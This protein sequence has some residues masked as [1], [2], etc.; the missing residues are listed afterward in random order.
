M[1]PDPGMS[2]RQA[3]EDFFSARARGA[4][5]EISARLAGSP[6]GLL[7]YDEV[8]RRFNV[9]ESASQ[10]LTEIPLDAIVGSV[11]RYNDFTRKLLPLRKE[12][13]DRWARVKSKM[14]E[15][16]G[17]PPIEVYQVGQAY[18]IIDGHHRASVA[19][20]LGATHI[21]AYVRQV[22]IRVPLTPEDDLEDLILKSEYAEFLKKTQLDE[23]HPEANLVMTIPG[24]YH[25]L[26]EHISAQQYLQSRQEKREIPFKAAVLGWYDRVYLPVVKL[27]QTRN[28]IHYFSDRTETDVYV[29]IM[30]YRL[31]SERELGW[32]V[33][34]RDAV[35][36]LTY[37]YAR[38]F[39]HRFS[40]FRKKMTHWLA[41]ASLEPAIP[42]GFW[43]QQRKTTEENLLGLFDT[44]LVALPG[45]GDSW[46][47]LNAGLF[48]ANNEHASI[49]GLTVIATE[50]HRSSPI[51]D[52]IRSRFIETCRQAGVEGKMAVEVGKIPNVI[53]ERS[54]WVDLVV[55]PLAYPP[56]QKSL[57]RLSSGIRT[58]IRRS[59]TPL[60]LVPP[61]APTTI[62]SAL[63][64]Y[65]GGRLADEALYM[66]AYLCLRFK[67][68]LYVI[69]IGG[70]NKDASL[71]L[72]R[73]R[74]Y[75]Q[76][77]GI[78]IVTY[79]EEQGDAALAIL[80]RSYILD[81]DVILMGGYEGGLMNEILSGSTVD[82]VLR[83]SQR[84]VL[85]C[86]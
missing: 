48:I 63:L 32:N 21:E 74:S 77:M 6:Y 15:P 12:D 69:T 67:M 36:N 75:L 42:P 84:M 13:G 62:R 33:T 65:G 17:L 10:K 45:T 72:Q 76:G 23:L 26:L 61:N 53:Y 39:G 11:S 57:Q 85:I 41:P 58:L 80:N 8:R 38:D 3:L 86:R 4:L 81:S 2:Y 9:L 25:K 31:R 79:I 35:E 59:A 71:L 40:R 78:N 83:G 22:F 7:Q 73:A 29:W 52:Q 18:F 68:D 27:I 46:N 49:S 55:I 44:I 14:E 66:A 28:T 82:Q 54:F 47:A 56:P 70:G 60:L 5:E 1:N 51:I 37:N 16:S 20:E 19:R 34:P 43:R 24:Q 50:Q 30:E 64:A